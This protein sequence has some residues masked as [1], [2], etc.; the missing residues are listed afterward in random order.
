[1]SVCGCRCAGNARPAQRPTAGGLPRAG[2]PTR[3]VAGCCSR[4]AAD[5]ARG[6]SKVPCKPVGG[7]PVATGTWQRSFRDH[8]SDRTNP[9][10]LCLHR[11]GLN[12]STCPGMHN[13]PRSQPATRRLR[14]S[15]DSAYT[16][17][18]A[19]QHPRRRLLARKQASRLGAVCT[20]C[21]LRDPLPIHHNVPLPHPPGR[22]IS[23]GCCVPRPRWLA[24]S[25]TCRACTG[26]PSPRASRESACL[27]PT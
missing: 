12:A 11:A 6:T 20:A 3:A 18:C 24:A 23:M 9:A 15:A 2:G 7:C 1:M 5:T 27:F 26:L 22:A 17:A 19:T 4:V 25:R 14:R 13:V 10:T 16:L 21:W 8:L